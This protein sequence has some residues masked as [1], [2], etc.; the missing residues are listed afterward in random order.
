MDLPKTELR[1]LAFIPSSFLP[2]STSSLFF[3]LLV[4][5]L[6]CCIVDSGRF[7]NKGSP[8]PLFSR[9]AVEAIVRTVRAQPYACG[10]IPLIPSPRIVSSPRPSSRPRPRPVTPVPV[11]ILQQ[12]FILGYQ[13]KS[14]TGAKCKST[15]THE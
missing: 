1:L 14:L 8:L 4:T 15:K 5:S 3:C 12:R 2:H 7:S 13:G 6:A 9:S 11:L 10:H